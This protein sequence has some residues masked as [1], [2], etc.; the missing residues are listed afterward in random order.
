M[1]ERVIT[2]TRSG[3]YESTEKMFVDVTADTNA[4]AFYTRLNCSLSDSGA[5]RTLQ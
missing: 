1:R 3:E 5:K 2:R 4:E